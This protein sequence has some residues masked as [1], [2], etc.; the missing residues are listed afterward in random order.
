ML[1]MER[2]EGRGTRRRVGLDRGESLQKGPSRTTIQDSAV[3][4]D[5]GHATYT[6]NG[7]VSQRFDTFLY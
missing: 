1:Q 5:I 2:G 4:L 7:T 6:S 3:L